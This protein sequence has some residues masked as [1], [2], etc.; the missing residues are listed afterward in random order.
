MEE[1]IARRSSEELG[2][3]TKTSFIYKFEYTAHFGELGTEHELCSVYVGEFTGEPNINAEE[4][5]D[6]RWMSASEIDAFLADE[7]TQTTPWFEMEW[8]RLKSEGVVD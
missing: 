3:A 4:I 7:K 6:Y 5:S 1:A 8:Q 2:F